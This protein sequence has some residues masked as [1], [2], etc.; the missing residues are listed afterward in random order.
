[1]RLMQDHAGPTPLPRQEPGELLPL[2]GADDRVA[3]LMTIPDIGELLGLT[4][5]AEVGD[6]ARLKSPR[7]LVGYA[8]LA[9]LSQPVGA[10]LAAA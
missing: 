9:S 8:G 7:K 4:I 1:M 5:A 10:E 2:A 6:I 3:V